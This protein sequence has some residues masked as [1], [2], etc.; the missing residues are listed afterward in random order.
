MVIEGLMKLEDAIEAKS[1]DS[2]SVMEQGAH[3]HVCVGSEVEDVNGV[4]SYTSCQHKLGSGHAFDGAKVHRVRE[5]GLQMELLL[6]SLETPS[7][8]EA[9]I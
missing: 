5:G 7:P 6:L 9:L 2:I 3:I 4:I 8:Q 1:N